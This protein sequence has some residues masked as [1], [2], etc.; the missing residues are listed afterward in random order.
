MSGSAKIVLDSTYGNKSGLLI[1]DG[2]LNLGGSGQLNGTGQS[3]SYI[4]FATTSSLESTSCSTGFATICITGS[5][6]SV[7]LNAQNGT[8][9]FTGSASA[10]EATAYKIK[11]EGSTVVNYE[12]GLMNMNFS[13][14]PSGTWSINS[15]GESQ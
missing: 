8:I 6:G 11:L 2:Y 14:G 15:W 13:S 10:K 1:S 9:W 12:S 7:I 5:A 4:L 3:G